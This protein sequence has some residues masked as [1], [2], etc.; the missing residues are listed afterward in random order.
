MKVL[1]EMVPCRKCNFD[2]DPDN[3][4][5]VNCL[6][7]FVGKRIPRKS[8]KPKYAGGLKARRKYGTIECPKCGDDLRII[9]FATNEVDICMKC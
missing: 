5:C 4:I 8:V 9:D 1:K 2:N 6:K 3:D 7:K